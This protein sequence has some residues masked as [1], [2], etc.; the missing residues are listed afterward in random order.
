MMSPCDVVAERLA[1][2]DP[3][4]ELAQHADD[5]PRCQGLLSVQRS[6]AGS[7]RSDATPAHGFAARMTVAANQRLV[8]RHRRRVVGYAALSAAAAAMATFLI[9]RQPDKAVAPPVA[10]TQPRLEAPAE[11]RD[12]WTSDDAPAAPDE[13]DE[14]DAP[15]EPTAEELLED[16]GQ[17]LEL[18]GEADE[19][20][21]ALFL[22]SKQAARRDAANWK[23]IEAPLSAY[24]RLL[25][26][27]D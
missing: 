13:A 16:E 15:L 3:L 12:P 4:A 21:R 24:D 26:Q 1:T 27:L 7:H 2:G 10:A 18:D 17:P 22:M 20:A 14:D 6:L 19:D 8:V 23:K 25:Q 5:C 11:P 9:V